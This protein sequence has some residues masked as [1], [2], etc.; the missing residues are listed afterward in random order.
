MQRVTRLAKPVVVVAF[1]VRKQWRCFTTGILQIHTNH[2]T[3]YVY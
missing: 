2:Y 3:R 1:T